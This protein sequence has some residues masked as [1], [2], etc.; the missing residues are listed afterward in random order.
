MMATQ[1]IPTACAA[2]EVGLDFETYYAAGYSVQDLGL[3]G[4]RPPI[5]RFDGPHRRGVGRR[6]TPWPAAV[7][8]PVAK[9]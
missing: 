8:L 9:R 3:L 5:R 2:P 6:D 4:L 1:A 7:P